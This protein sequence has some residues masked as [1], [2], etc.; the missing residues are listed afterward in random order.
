[1]RVA[2]AYTPNDRLTITPSVFYQT[3]QAGSFSAQDNPPNDRTI[4][5]RVAAPEQLSDDYILGTVKVEYALDD[6]DILSS[7][8]YSERTPSFNEDGSDYLAETYLPLFGLPSVYVTNSVLG[9]GEEKLFTQELRLATSGDQR[10]QFVVGAFYED[11]SRDGSL[12]WTAPDLL[13]S[14]PFLASSIP[15]GLLFRQTTR[16]EREQISAFGEGSFAFT[17]QLKLSVGARY[18]RY[19]TTAQTDSNAPTST[20][21]DGISPRVSLSYQATPD[22]LVY[23][24]VAR[25]FRPGGPNRS[26]PT[27]NANACRAQ[28]AAAGITI[29]ANGAIDPYES[30]SLWNYEVG[31]KTTWAG[32]RLRANVATYLTEWDNI[33]QLYF[34]SC[35]FGSTANLGKAEIRGV[36]LD[37]NAQLTDAFS[38]Y[39][40]VNYADAEL[41]DG[42]AALNVPAGTEV[43]NVPE[44]T[45]NLNAQY[46]FGGPFGSDA[47]FVA[48]YRFIDESY[49]DTDRTNPRKFQ[50]AYDL[51]NARLSFTRGNRT[52]AIYANNISDENPGV[53]NFLST[54]GAVAS[55]ERMF[56]I[57]PRTVG[58]SLRLDY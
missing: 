8:N 4:R 24:T 25:G 30:D 2:L 37:F 58:V 5:R 13:N 55:R 33:Q 51:I 17:D 39:G 3:L 16:F 6:F 54:F 1:V 20:D 46:D 10:L 14:L 36:E 56:T 27:A 53:S 21:E 45:V 40:G 11:F 42:I 48:T 29:D 52:L 32:G 43:Q 50:D 26:A 49:R 22:A 18:Y 44:W 31:A 47:S 41:V 34:P 57:Q 19:S 12:L 35:G 23:S 38:V 7:T 15:G 9:S 28:Y